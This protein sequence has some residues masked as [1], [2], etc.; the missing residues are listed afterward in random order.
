MACKDAD[1]FPDP[2]KFDLDRPVENYIHFGYG[3]HECLGREI[4]LIFV[5]SLI[6]IVAGLKNLRPAPGVMGTLKSIT[7][8][9][10]RS[11]LT[12]DWSELTFDPTSKPHFLY[13][14][15]HLFE[16]QTD[17]VQHGNFTVTVGAKASISRPSPQPQRRMT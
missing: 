5:T 17:R 3:G 11:Y 10:E 16:L 8:G 7:I 12:S 6:K 9:G 1:V 14:P 15:L 2:S 4:A 13:H